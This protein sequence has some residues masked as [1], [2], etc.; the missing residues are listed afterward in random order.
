[1]I[2]GRNGVCERPVTRL[3]KEGHCRA[4]KG[5]GAPR[6]V[7]GPQRK[8][9]I[10]GSHFTLDGCERSR[11]GTWRDHVDGLGNHGWTQG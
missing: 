11:L 5:R 2:R 10:T 3:L 7:E 9:C 4:R 8:L 6:G 1:M